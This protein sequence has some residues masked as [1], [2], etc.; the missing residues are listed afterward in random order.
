[1]PQTLAEQKSH[2]LSFVLKTERTILRRVREIVAIAIAGAIGAVS[3]SAA[4]AD[5]AAAPDRSWGAGDPA[6]A[7][8]APEYLDMKRSSYYVPMRDGV[9]IAIDVWLPVG[10]AAGTKLPA[11]LEQTRYYRSALVKSDPH[12]ACHPPLKP[13]VNGF[14]TRGYAYVIV[15]VRGTGASFGTRSSEYSDDEVKDGS[16]IVD[17][18]VRQDWSNGK[19]GSQG[20]SYEGTTAEMLLRNHNP[21]VKAVSP[22]FSGY[23]FY[24]EIVFPGG[25]RSTFVKYWS[26]LIQSLDHAALAESSPILGPC[27]VDEDKDQSLL[28]AAI[29]QH[30]GN[31]IIGRFAGHVSFRDDRFEG[32][33]ADERSPIYY[34]RAV[35]A[36]NVPLY[37]I[38]GW[39]DSGYALGAIRRFINSASPKQRVLIGPWNHGAHSF[40]GPGT[41]QAA[42]SSFDLASE[43]LRYFDFELKGI[44]RG[45]SSSPPVRY[46]T[47]GSNRWQ[48]ADR[49]PP[50]NS[51]LVAW[52]FDDHNGLSQ[53]VAGAGGV[54]DYSSDGTASSGEHNRWRAT[55]G[56]FPVFYPDRATED[57]QLLTYTSS[58]LSEDLEVTGDPVAH[59]FLSVDG[60]DSDVIV[61]LE[62]VTPDGETN[63]VTEGELKASRR[64]HGSLRFRTPEPVHSDRRR[65][66]LKVTPGQ[67][68]QLDIG[69]LPL[70]HVFKAGNRIR[71][72]L[73][74]A[75]RAQF[76]ER[77]IEAA[78]W[79]V[80]RTAAR[81][82]RIELPVVA[83]DRSGR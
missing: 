55:M 63:Y 16:E 3:L 26:D 59:V 83:A 66:A 7:I 39:Y 27:P 70:S 81:Q 75:D 62:E 45:F 67:V 36:A 41:H 35:D 9:K 49:W 58:P 24:T 72:A 21:A 14:V 38:V 25:I 11:I 56:P 57:R 52:Y 42:A 28:R 79:K 15:D 61:F 37:A 69:L 78:K 82:S 1:M 34:Q 77:P 13:T 32:L 40:Y 73:A 46:F 50:R 4:G 30:A 44:D 53:K 68:T 23:D 74:S 51:H 33:G 8:R 47:T 12:G 65:D 2:P 6:Y 80:F 29:A 22:S 10:M 64:R 43:K 19:V 76:Q 54:D 5:S 20:Q 18:I 71:I 31:F 17:W 48:G 60:T